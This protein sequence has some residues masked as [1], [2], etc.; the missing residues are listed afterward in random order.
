MRFPRTALLL[1]SMSVAGCSM[2]GLLR[3]D[4]EAPTQVALS[5]YAT[6]NVNPNADALPADTS[7]S[8]MQTPDVTTVKVDAS[9]KE[10]P[11]LVNLSGGSEAELAEKM[12]ALLDY[13]RSP[14]MGAAEPQTLLISPNRGAAAVV[15]TADSQLRQDGFGEGKPVSRVAMAATLAPYV[16]GVPSRFSTVASDATAVLAT[17]PVPASPLA[18]SPREIK[19]SIESLHEQRHATVVD[20]LPVP[21]RGGSQ[22]SELKAQVGNAPALGQY[23]DGPTVPPSAADDGAVHIDGTPIF[24]KVL[25]LKDDSVFLNADRDVLQNDLKKA[26][27]STYVDDDDYVLQPSQFKYVDFKKIDKNARY[28]AVLANFHDQVSSTWKQV[29]RID[30][31]GYKYSL[32]LLFQ[33]NKVVIVDES[34]HQPPR[35]KS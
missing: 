10:G 31:D 22:R 2:S 33:G 18:T 6:P 1:A 28:I 25:Q 34:Y 20:D 27:G 21:L 29:L 17:K 12:M 16:I 24:F 5:L 8:T 3:K 9:V 13:L 11:Y 23:A 7:A 15:N 32:L 4:R 19:L 30:P 35:K 26:L 14:D